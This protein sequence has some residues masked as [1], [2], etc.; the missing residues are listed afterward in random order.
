MDNMQPCLLIALLALAHAAHAQAPPHEAHAHQHSDK[1]EAAQVQSGSVNALP[2]A[3]DHVPPD[4][5]Q[6]IMAPMNDAEMMRVMQMDDAASFFQFKFDTLE[7]TLADAASATRWNAQLRY[8]GDFDKLL[9]RSEGE[10]E[11][12]RTDA[13]VE[14][15]WNHAF[16]SFWDWQ[17]GARR[18]FGSGPARTWVGFGVQGLA[19]YWFDVEATAFVGDRGRTAL[20]LR[21]DYDILLS[22]RWILQPEL[23][24][25]VYAQSDRAHGVATGLSDAEMGVRLR[26]EIRREFAPYIGVVRSFRRTADEPFFSPEH[27]R[28]SQMRIVAGVRI[29]F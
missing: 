16:A 23:Q 14:A 24:I 15:Y 7:H 25:N 6:Q 11:S 21:V 2:A 1:P 20:S 28:G 29:W 10:R 8:G 12:G 5:P 3:L 9:L 22:Q 19:P 17:W 18:D 26:Y 13:R 27:P 4:M